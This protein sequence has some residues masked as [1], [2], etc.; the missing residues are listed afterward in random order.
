MTAY[1][2][3]RSPLSSAKVFLGYWIWYLI[4]SVTVIP[5]LDFAGTTN[6]F[7]SEIQNNLKA[8]FPLYVK[9]LD[10][11]QRFLFFSKLESNTAT[12]S[13]WNLSYMSDQKVTSSVGRNKLPTH[14]V[15]K[16]CSQWQKE[17]L[18]TTVILQNEHF[19]YSQFPQI[20]N[21]YRYIIGCKLRLRRS[22]AIN[23]WWTRHGQRTQRDRSMFM[24]HRVSNN[25][26]LTKATDT[27]LLSRKK[28]AASKS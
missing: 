5:Q 14:V 23:A 21:R 3:L 17:H 6:Q 20:Y 22:S 10:Q 13:E 2:P 8:F 27:H 11:R 1:T 16:L 25:F 19:F 26:I 28:L 9:D 7:F 18:S 15:G 24:I 4:F 12:I